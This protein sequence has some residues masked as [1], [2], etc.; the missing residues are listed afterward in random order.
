MLKITRTLDTRFFPTV[1]VGQ[2]IA[3]DIR[4]S[5][6]PARAVVRHHANPLQGLVVDVFF[7]TGE[8]LYVWLHEAL[9]EGSIRSLPPVEWPG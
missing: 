5:V 4:T 8:E 2:D 1:Q 6:T 3:D 9:A 7:T